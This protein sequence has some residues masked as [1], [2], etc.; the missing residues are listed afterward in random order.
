M[1]QLSVLTGVLPQ[2]LW[3]NSPLG[4]GIT[5]Q[6]VRRRMRTSSSSCEREIAHRL[7]RFA[8]YLISLDPG[9]QNI[10]FPVQYDEVGIGSRTQS[11]LPVFYA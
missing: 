2:V 7:E 4:F 9:I 1:S 3:R 6:F 11:A 5:G 8:P 10:P